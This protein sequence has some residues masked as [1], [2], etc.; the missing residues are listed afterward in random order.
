MDKGP[1]SRCKLCGGGRAPNHRMTLLVFSILDDK[2][3]PNQKYH[4]NDFGKDMDMSYIKVMKKKGRRMVEAPIL[5]N[6]M[7]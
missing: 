1:P 2:G 5:E 3:V 4:T 7:K 6:Q